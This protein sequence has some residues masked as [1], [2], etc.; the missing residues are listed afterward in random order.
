MTKTL[1][2]NYFS[3]SILSWCFVS[4]MLTMLSL[5]VNAAVVCPTTDAIASCYCSEVVNP[6]NTI[7][8]SCY[9]KNLTDSQASDILDALLTTSS[10]SPLSWLDF[11]FNQLTKVPIQIKSFSQLNYVYPSGNDITSVDSAAFNFPDA[12][13]PLRFFTL[14]GNQLTHR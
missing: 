6:P 9:D 8:F 2:S 4:S 5:S 11:S 3:A 12:A 7:H 13:H 10:V 14:G 1:S